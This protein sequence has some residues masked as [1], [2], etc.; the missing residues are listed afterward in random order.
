MNLTTF[1]LVI[2][3]AC[4]GAL[5]ATPQKPDR[6]E[7]DNHVFPIGVW[8]SDLP[9]ESYFK[10]F[11]DKRPKEFMGS[12]SDFRRGYAAYWRVADRKLWLVYLEYPTPESVPYEQVDRLTP[13]PIFLSPFPLQRIFT[14]RGPAIFADW[15]S[16]DIELERKVVREEEVP[17]GRIQTYEGRVLVFKK[18][19]LTKVEKRSV[20]VLFVREPEEPFL[21]TR[22]G[23]P[24]LQQRAEQDGADQP[25]TAPESKSGNKQK[26]E[27]ESEAAPR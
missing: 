6:I 24:P 22:L 23:P 3:L 14:G 8:F 13:D 1:T 25:A 2:S 15:Y 27:P 18:G 4:I 11:P 26:P 19:V 12:R 5:L 21:R 20:D 17:K 7:F 9:L 10:R 16:G